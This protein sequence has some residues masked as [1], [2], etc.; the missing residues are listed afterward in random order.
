MKIFAFYLPQFHEI[1][2]N[3]EWWGKGFTE[4]TNVKK[5][6]KIY[7]KQTPPK[8]PLN[9]NYYNLLDRE[10]VQWQTQLMDDYK[11]DGLI[12]YHYYFE[13]RK[14]LEKPAENLLKNKDINQKFFFCWANHSWNRAWK[15][16]R[17]VLLEQTYGDE[18]AW[19]DHFQ[20][21]LPFFKDARYEKKNNKPLFMIFRPDFKEKN[22]IIDYFNKRCIDEG[23]DG[24]YIF[25]SCYAIYGDRYQEFK[26][27]LNPISNVFF[28]QAWLGEYLVRKNDRYR[29]LRR[30]KSKLSKMGIG[31]YIWTING[32]KCL[33]AAMNYKSEFSDATPGLFF[34]WDNTPRHGKRGYII[35]PVTHP[36]FEKYMNH[37]KDS[38]YMFVNAWNEWCEGMILEPTEENGYKYLEWIKAWKDQ[39]E[40]S[41][42]S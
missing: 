5:A 15:G 6:T 19:E 37:Y 35:T 8:V 17:E 32:D 20:Y 34:E 39:I 26:H 4:W 27:N 22:D 28:R 40:K 41:S 24:I 31:S 11:V 38:E 25:E 2:E 18:S 42:E 1:P 7:R 21:L 36:V 14:L 10:T 13:G 3:N 30:I 33:K 23:F 16:S 12:Y 29:L 9:N